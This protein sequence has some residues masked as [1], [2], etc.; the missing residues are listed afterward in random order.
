[1]SV[2]KERIESIIKRELAPLIV[3][4]LNDPS[5]SFVSITDVEVTND[6]SFAT[7]YVSFL[8]D[9]DK[10]KGMEALRRAKGILRSEVAKSLSIRR[11]PEL[12]FKLDESS[13]HG[14]RIDTILESLRKDEE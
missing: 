10:K 5:L 6:F 7:I 9:K 14:T 2:K 13:E 8:Q 12:L 1:M 3:N 11:T 4:R